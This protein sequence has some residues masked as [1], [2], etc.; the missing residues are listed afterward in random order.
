MFVGI[1]RGSVIPGLLKWCR[2]SSIHSTTV[3]RTPAT[4]FGSRFEQRN[5]ERIYAYPRAQG[6]SHLTQEVGE[7]KPISFWTRKR[8]LFTPRLSVLREARDPRTISK[9]TG[10]FQ[11]GSPD[12]EKHSCGLILFRGQRSNQASPLHDPAAGQRPTARWLGLCA[13]GFYHG[14]RRAA[15]VSP[16]HGQKKPTEAGSKVHWA[17]RFRIPR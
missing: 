8:T 6:C 11:Q 12:F 3:P 13:S 4:F 16:G 17:A 5:A 10:P 2:I 14:A 7:G 15:A 9:G 1:Y